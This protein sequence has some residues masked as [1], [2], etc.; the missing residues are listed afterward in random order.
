V[1]AGE[2]LLAAQQ[3]LL[4]RGEALVRQLSA[5]RSAR[6]QERAR[7]AQQLEEHAGHRVHTDRFRDHVL[8][9]VGHDLRN[10]LGVIVMSA[11]LLQKKGGLT[12]WQAQTVDRIRSASTRMRRIIDDLLGYTRSR[13]GK[14]IPIERAPADLDVICRRVLSEMGA[15]HPKRR[16]VY[17]AQGEATGEWDSA[18]LEHVVS[19]LV[20]SAIDHGD[21]AW[22][23]QVTVAAG[24]DLAILEVRSRGD[25]LP[26]EM[27]LHAFDPFHLAPDE[28]ARKGSGL[29]LGLFIAREILSGH[30]GEIGIRSSE[31]EGM[32]VSARLP[33]RVPAASAHAAHPDA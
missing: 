20:A 11:V 14:G 7:L 13:L 6:D 5:D 9:I 30:G 19:N 17:T 18:R 8:S 25:P 10:P 33:R 21:P 23:I 26:L 12:G 24:E 28:Q 1:R 2:R 3:R 22:P 31:E 16:I 27:L 32:V 4:E 15:A 29:G